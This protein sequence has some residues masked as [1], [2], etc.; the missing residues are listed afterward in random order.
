MTISYEK[1]AR[2]LGVDPDADL[3]P[4]ADAD[5]RMVIHESDAAKRLGVTEAEIVRLVLSG[6]LTAG[7]RGPSGDLWIVESSLEAFRR[8]S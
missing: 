3:R 4:R 5:G 2:F 8:A 7:S 6:A 1:A